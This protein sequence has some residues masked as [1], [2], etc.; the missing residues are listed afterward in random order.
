MSAPP[1]ITHLLYLHGFRSSPQSNKALT[2]GHHL[3]LHHPSVHWW[4]PQL[5]AS[6]RAAM[7]LLLQGIRN[8]PHQ[9]MAVVGS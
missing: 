1:P 7:T 4:C 3:A 5:P 2:M 9:S 8:W 6:P